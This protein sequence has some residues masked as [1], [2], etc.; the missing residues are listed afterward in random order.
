MELTEE[1]S[2]KLGLTEVSVIVDK[3]HVYPHR[4]VL[5]GRMD[6]RECIVKYSDDDPDSIL[7]EFEI[8]RVFHE[9]SGGCSPEMLACENVAGGVACIMEKMQGVY[10]GEFLRSGRGDAAVFRDIACQLDRLTSVMREIGMSHR[11][12]GA[13]NVFVTDGNV[14][15]VFDFQNA[16]VSTQKTDV[17]ERSMRISRAFIYKYR[18]KHQ[19]VIGLFNDRG[20]MLSVLGS[21]YPLGIE[22]S[23][24][25]GNDVGAFDFY[26]PPGRRQAIRFV[27]R[28]V[29]VLFL[30]LF[31][32]GDTKAA[33]KLRMKASV[34]MPSL[35]FWL[36]HGV[37]GPRRF[38][39]DAGGK[40][41]SHGR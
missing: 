36:K 35:R 39:R 8:G 25:W 1:L 14:V 15:K 41:A 3:R 34:V 38:V 7:N 32:R 12:F 17:F 30:R 33:G 5:S 28:S 10:L 18:S 23:R 22:L 27:V 24:L 19:P 11:D 6:G 37:S 4:V 13:G 40:G 20:L 9:A 26:C 31:V 2:E 16:V 21:R 29:G